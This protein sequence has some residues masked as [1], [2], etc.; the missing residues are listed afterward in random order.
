MEVFDKIKLM[1]SIKGW[2]QEEMAEKLDIAL[3][4][5]AKIEHGETDINLSRLKQIAEV[6]GIELAQLFNLNEK[7]ILNLFG[8]NS[9]NNS[10]IN[11]S[12]L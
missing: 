8:N 9:G 4:S 10:Y 1:R 2:T 11:S 12:V 7:S 3:R 6:M 5:Y